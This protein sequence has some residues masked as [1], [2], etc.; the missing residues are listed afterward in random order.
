MGK[1]VKLARKYSVG[2]GIASENKLTIKQCFDKYIFTK[3]MEGQTKET[4]ATKIRT[5]KQFHKVIDK[6]FGYDLPQQLRLDDVRQVIN[7]FQTEYILH[8]EDK[9]VSDF[10]KTKGLAHTTINSLIT[11]NRAFYNWLLDEG[12]IHENPFDKVK[13]LKESVSI[14]ALSNQEIKMLLQGFNQKSFEGFRAYVLTVLLLDT[15]MRNTEAIETKISDIDFSR[16]VILITAD[17]AKTNRLRYVP[18]SQKTNKL[19]RELLSETEE[20]NTEYLFPTVYGNRPFDKRFYRT[21]LEDVSKNQGMKHVHPHMLRHTFATQYLMNGGDA[22]SLQKILGHT[23]LD[24]TMRYVEFTQSDL[25]E[26]HCNFSPIAN[27]K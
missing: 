10:Y 15:G 26:K 2:A 19:L 3:K 4:I 1:R 27:L 22:I 12:Y 13:M 18:F 11:S 7:H 16:N 23:K 25:S 5:H 6:F 24:M 20:V 8:E 21:Q 9:N 14:D 17:R